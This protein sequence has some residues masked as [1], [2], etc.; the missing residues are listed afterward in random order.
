MVALDEEILEIFLELVVFDLEDIFDV[1][2]N[3]FGWS[4]FGWATKEKKVPWEGMI[5]L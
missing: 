4:S 2:G 3:V 5:Y 1:F